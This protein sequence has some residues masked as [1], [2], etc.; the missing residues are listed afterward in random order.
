MDVDLDRK[1]MEKILEEERKNK[2]DFLKNLIKEIEDE[3][4]DLEL[5][6]NHLCDVQT[7]VVEEHIDEDANEL[8]ERIAELEHHSIWIN[9]NKTDLTRLEKELQELLDLDPLK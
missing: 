7:T 6:Y 1:R 5:E 4:G 2:I 8:K 3:T 9:S